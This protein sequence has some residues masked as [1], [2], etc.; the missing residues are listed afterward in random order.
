MDTLRFSLDISQLVKENDNILTVR[1]QDFHDSEEIPRGKQFWK[2]ESSSIWY[3][4]ATAGI[5]RDLVWLE[6]VEEFFIKNVKFTPN[7]D[8]GTVDIAIKINKL[9]ANQYIRYS[10]SF[11]GELLVEDVIKGCHSRNHSNSG[12]I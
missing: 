11:K 4:N 10:I 8:N 9:A 3:T 12:Y 6:P 5:W 2:P 1:V 7:I